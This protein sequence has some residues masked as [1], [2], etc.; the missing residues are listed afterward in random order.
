MIGWL[1]LESIDLTTGRPGIVS[2]SGLDVSVV[3]VVEDG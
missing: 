1:C 3:A 2:C